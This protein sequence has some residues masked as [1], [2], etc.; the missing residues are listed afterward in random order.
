MILFM[1]SLLRMR[2]G[3]SPGYQSESI[4]VTG[5]GSWYWG[6]RAGLCAVDQVPD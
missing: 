5:A 3:T 2:P 1:I 6:S 4:A